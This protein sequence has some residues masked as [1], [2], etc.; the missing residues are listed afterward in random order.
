[1]YVE[2]C[3]TNGCN[4]IFMYKCSFTSDCPNWLWDYFSAIFV[5]LFY[6]VA[7]QWK[8]KF[9]L[10]QYVQKAGIFKKYKLFNNFSICCYYDIIVEYESITVC[11]C[12]NAY[13]YFL[14]H[15][16]KK[17]CLLLFYYNNYI[18]APYID[19]YSTWEKLNRQMLLRR[20]LFPV[21]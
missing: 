8:L 19:L 1:M 18:Y 13:F 9:R 16:T 4:S 11:S 20:L 12:V 7:F 21:S 15:A 17:S 6:L 14:K 5:Q 3:L 10:K 2:Q